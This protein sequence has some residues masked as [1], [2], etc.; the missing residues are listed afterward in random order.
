MTPGRR[1]RTSSLLVQCVL[2]VGIGMPVGMLGAGWPEARDLFH[3]SSGALGAVVLGYG[4]GRLVTSPVALPI[5]RRWHIRT[6][7]TAMAAA[8]A[9]SCVVVGLTRSFAVLVAAFAVLGLLSGG[10]DSLGNRYQ[11]VVRDVGSAGL[12]FGSFGIG[13]S[14]GPAVVAVAGW[15]TGY[16][17]AAAVVACAGVLASSRQVAWPVELSQ[18]EAPRSEQRTG[19]V[20]TS[21]LVLSLAAFAIYV[22]I[23]VLTANWAASYLKDARGISGRTAA[24]AMSGFWA[25]MTLGRLSLGR[26]AAGGRGVSSARLLT[27]AGTVVLAVYATV[28]LLPPV[29]AAMALTV[30]GAALAGVFPTLMSTT[31]DR[32]GVGAAGR[33][34][35][36]QLL[37]AN[38]S[39]TGLSVAVGIGVDRAGDALPGAVLAALAIGGLPI[40]LRTQRVHADPDVATP[41]DRA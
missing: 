32:V 22:G 16:L 24:W 38:L 8:L 39:A 35:G 31:A 18:P 20:A 25:G 23:E 37:T 34:M 36:W 29:A 1:R 41:L 10:L 14:L 9:A 2:Y 28:P 4:L 12:M 21:V 19:H 5:L 7:N 33:V 6:A 17:V 30:G 3:R 13:S 26:L 27:V 11:T 40:L 15:T